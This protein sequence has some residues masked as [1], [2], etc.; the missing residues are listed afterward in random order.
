MAS[1]LDD[2]AEAVGVSQDELV[3]MLTPARINSKVAMW[4]DTVM[5]EGIIPLGQYRSTG[6][7]LL[8]KV[9]AE[10]LWEFVPKLLEC[11]ADVNWRGVYGQSVLLEVLSY[12][13]YHYDE[14]EDSGVPTEV[15]K[16]L[17]SPVNINWHDDCGRTALYLA[18]GAF[19]FDLAL[20]LL[21]LGADVNIASGSG[22]TALHMAVETQGKQKD[23]SERREVIQR[24]ITPQTINAS[25]RYCTSPLFWA[26]EHLPGCGPPGTWDDVALLL[27]HGA[28]VNMKPTG[29]KLP[30]CYCLG[31]KHAELPLVKQLIPNDPHDIY[32]C[33]IHMF[34]NR[35]RHIESTHRFELLRCLLR[36]LVPIKLNRIVLDNG[37][38]LWVNDL[39]IQLEQHDSA[40]LPRA[41]RLDRVLQQTCLLLQET[42]IITQLDFVIHVVHQGEIY[43]DKIRVLAKTATSIPASLRRLSVIAIRQHIV[44]HHGISG[45]DNI[46]DKLGLPGLLLRMLKWETLA[47]DLNKMWFPNGVVDD[48]LYNI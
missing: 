1:N 21:E 23:S 15:I 13:C 38:S 47:V 6:M 12:D 14:D 19:R 48:N 46:P 22:C 33:V 3:D 44:N 43:E 40:I 45:L 8:Q 10:G 29:G 37:D 16:Q 31:Y 17:T 42:C 5:T 4:K 2:L 28:S 39:Q 27:K 18:V 7:T 20:A 30:L 9:G 41:K 24:L 25:G 11:G 32:M 34:T 26:I 36:H 35:L